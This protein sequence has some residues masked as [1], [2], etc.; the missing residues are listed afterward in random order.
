MRAEA[1]RKGEKVKN[2]SARGFELFHTPPVHK[3]SLRKIIFILNFV[4]NYCQP[5]F[6]F[7]FSLKPAIIEHIKFIIVRIFIPY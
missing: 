2:T 6:C 4:K 3:S 5:G 1:R 7:I